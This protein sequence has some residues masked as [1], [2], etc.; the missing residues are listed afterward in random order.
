MIRPRRSSSTARSRRGTRLRRVP[1]PLNVVT[2]L[3]TSALSYPQVTNMNRLFQGAASFNGDLSSWDVGR[4]TNMGYMFDGATSFVR[5]LGG[6]WATSTAF[7]TCMFNNSP[8]SI[9]GK[10]NDA[11]G[12]PQ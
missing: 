11:N 2:S 8:G 10:N 3:L 1:P 7:K 12:T 4:V 9:A 5:E 6:A